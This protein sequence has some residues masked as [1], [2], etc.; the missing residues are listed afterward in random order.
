MV[1][2]FKATGVA[3]LLF[4]TTLATSDSLEEDEPQLQYNASLFLA[5]PGTLNTRDSDTS[6]LDL[7]ARA[8]Y[9]TCPSGY[10]SCNALSTRCCPTEDLCCSNGYCA[11]PGAKCCTI[12]TCPSGWNCCGNAGHCSPVGGEC[13]SNGYYCKAGYHCRSRSGRIVCCPASGCVG[14]VGTGRIGN[15]VSAD[16]A[17]SITRETTTTTATTATITRVRYSYYYTTYYW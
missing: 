1:A 7:F 16:E 17:T 5:E 8:S 14:E 10:G 4:F 11:K 2:I 15:T 9:Y 3:L 6:G 12:G 13:C